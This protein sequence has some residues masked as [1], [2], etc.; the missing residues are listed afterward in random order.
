VKP[1][2]AAE[3]PEMSG[4]VDDVKNY[5]LENPNNIPPLYILEFSFNPSADIFD[6]Y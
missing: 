4:L 3:L 5:Y 2:V 6:A 1:S